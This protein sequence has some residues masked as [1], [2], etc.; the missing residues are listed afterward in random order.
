[1]QP[2]KEN[3]VIKSFNLSEQIVANMQSTENIDVIIND[4]E[5]KK[6]YSKVLC[7]PSEKDNTKLVSAGQLRLALRRLNSLLKDTCIK[8][9]AID[10]EY[11]GKDMIHGINPETTLYL[12]ISNEKILNQFLLKHSF[13]VYQLKPQHEYYLDKTIL[14]GFDAAEADRVEK[15]FFTRLPYIYVL[16][17]L[18]EFRAAGVP[19]LVDHLRG[20]GLF[21]N[22]E[23]AGYMMD[24]IWKETMKIKPPRR[25]KLDEYQDYRDLFAYT[26]YRLED[27][28]PLLVLHA[29]Y[30][31]AKENGDV[32]LQQLILVSE[33]HLLPDEQINEILAK[34]LELSN[35]DF[36]YNLTQAGV[37]DLVMYPKE[38]LLQVFD[39]FE[40][41]VFP[42]RKM[43]SD[44][45]ST[46]NYLQYE[47]EVM[48]YYLFLYND[49]IERLRET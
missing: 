20:I 17:Q 36:L 49:L 35:E 42:E 21:R 32:E 13:P 37:R 15:D 19:A 44:Y 12:K 11:S 25:K 41:V 47:E 28:N 24:Y 23:K 10:Q 29:L 5:I 18:L 33:N 9:I 2:L 31:Q 22:Y 38:N 39:K 16:R 3:W 48:S 27:M 40:G 34:A 26:D 4:G 8:T 46:A 1:M 14:E 45:S 43:E 6:L 30:C 7:Q